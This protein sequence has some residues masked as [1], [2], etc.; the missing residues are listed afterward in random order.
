MDWVAISCYPNSIVLNTWRLV[1]LHPRRI[2]LADG[3][4]FLRDI[5]RKV[6]EKTPGLQVV[7]EV[8]DFSNLPATLRQTNA[9]WIVFSLPPHLHIPHEL[10]AAL[11][12]EFPSVRILD[13]YTDGSQVRVKRMGYRDKDFGGLTWDVLLNILNETP[14]MDGEA[15]KGRS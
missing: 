10:K 15:E 3:S 12:K 4:R 13:F 6:I 9:E 2:I 11:L 5:L 1:N 7:G 8:S 14:H